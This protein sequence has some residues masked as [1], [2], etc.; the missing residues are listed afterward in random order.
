M[1]TPSIGKVIANLWRTV[2]TDLFNNYRPE[3]H[4]MRGRPKSAPTGLLV[5]A[6][7]P[8]DHAEEA[9][10]N[11]LQ[12]YEYWVGKYG[13]RRANAIFNLQCLGIVLT[14]WCD[15]VMKRLKLLNFLRPSQ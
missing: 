15:W 9:L 7:T 12:R 6:L 3:R 2:T 14:F 5:D 1:K 13:R 4:Y 10:V 8:P 11:I